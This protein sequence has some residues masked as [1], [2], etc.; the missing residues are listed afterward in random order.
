MGRYILR[1]DE[2][3]SGRLDRFNFLE[4]AGLIQHV[5]PV[6]G[7]HFSIKPD[8]NKFA[9]VVE[10]DLCLRIYLDSMVRPKV[11]P[12]THVGQEIARILPPVDPMAV[13]KRLGEAVRD[14]VTSMDICRVL[15]DGTG[16]MRMSAP[17]EVLKR[18]PTGS[19]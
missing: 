1:P 8:S 13:L 12:I 7:M 2:L 16:G 3:S 6:G 5:P 15:L 18:A 19:S 4:Q 11:I 17:I 9:A 10:G 14:K